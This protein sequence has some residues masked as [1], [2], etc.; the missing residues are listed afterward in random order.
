MTSSSRVILV[1]DWNPVLDPNL[2][3]GGSSSGTNILDAWNFCKFIERLDLVDKFRERY[4]NN[5]EWTWTGK[6]ASVQYYSYANRVL[7]KRV[8]LDFLGGLSFEVYKSL[9]RSIRLD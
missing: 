1:G 3:Q 9:S 6:S 2:D 4:P 8:D 5:S 7:F